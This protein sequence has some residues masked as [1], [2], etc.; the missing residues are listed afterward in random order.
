MINYAVVRDIGLSFFVKS[1]RSVYERID[2]F[3]D[4]LA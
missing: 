3:S 4:I 2:E 1:F